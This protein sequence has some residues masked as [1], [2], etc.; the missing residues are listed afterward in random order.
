MVKRAFKNYFCHQKNDKRQ[1]GFTWNFLQPPVQVCRCVCIPYFKLNAPIFCCPHFFEE[2]LNHQ[3]RINKMVNEH[4]VDYHP[5]PAVLT[6]KDTSSHISSGLQRGLSLQNI[7]WSFSQTC[8]SHHGCGKFYSIKIT[9]RYTFES[10]KMNLFIFI[11]APKQN[12]PPGGR[13]LPISPEQRFRKIYFPPTERGEDY[14][15]GK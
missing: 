3:V 8:I 14:G 12:F 10:K 9:G 13:E 6:F 4:T 15:A 7:S 5:S 2:Y 11:H 1:T